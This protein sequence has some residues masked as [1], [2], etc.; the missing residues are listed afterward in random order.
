MSKALSNTSYIDSIDKELRG[1]LNR[2][3]MDIKKLRA[4]GKRIL[5][6]LSQELF[7]AR[8]DCI[9][10]NSEITFGRWIEGTIGISRSSAYRMIAVCE[11]FARPK[12][13]QPKPNDRLL[14]FA[15]FDDSALYELAKKDTPEQAVTEAIK[16][17]KAGKGLT[18]K[19]A[20]ELIAKY[21][22]PESE[23]DAENPPA[24]AASE[25]VSEL[26]SESG[27]EVSEEQRDALEEYEEET[28]VELLES[29]ADGVQSLDTAIETGVVPDPTIEEIIDKENKEIESFCRGLMKHFE[30][31]CPETPWTSSHGLL[32][33]AL[34]HVRSACATIRTAKCSC[35]CPKCDGEGCAI[36]LDSCRLPKYRKDQLS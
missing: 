18:H 23:P 21:K 9:E 10:H 22:E 33:T 36:C 35:A 5:F 34:Q 6:A 29:V 24:V 27:V 15:A 8:Q 11:R 3:E 16:I 25:E 30:Q 12:L 28:Q 17:A 31:N 4:E 1:R 13:G 26:I 32:D 2:R 19:A 20:K 7:D 14:C